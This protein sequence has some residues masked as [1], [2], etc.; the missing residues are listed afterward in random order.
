M[1]NFEQNQNLGLF[2]GD[3][4][5]TLRKK[6]FSRENGD[7]DK[8]RVV[9]ERSDRGSGVGGGL[10]V[11]PATVESAKTGGEAGKAEAD[12]KRKEDYGGNHWWRVRI[13][14]DGEKVQ[15]SWTGLS[16]L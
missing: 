10:F 9:A 5:N 1:G 11:V 13:V 14:S 3:S 8:L 15:R 4:V 7:N 6:I 2:A 16:H 12:G